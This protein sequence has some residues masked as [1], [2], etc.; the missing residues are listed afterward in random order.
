MYYVEFMPF[1][2]VG[3]ER[4]RV[5]RSP[6]GSLA[7]SLHVVKFFFRSAH[8]LKTNNGSSYDEISSLPKVI[9]WLF[10]DVSSIV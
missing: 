5:G 3:R 6:R 9:W 4:S 7:I 10:H 2:E 1:F 8:V